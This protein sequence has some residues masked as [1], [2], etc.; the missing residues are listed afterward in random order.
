ML[1]P[2]GVNVDKFEQMAQMM[3]TPFPRWGIA[4]FAISLGI[5]CFG[6]ATELALS[7]SYMFGEG[8]GWN[9]SEDPSPS[10]EA[11]FS[12]VYTVILILATI[13]LLFGVDPLQ[14][15]NLSMALTA[16]TLPLAVIPFLILMND[17]HYLRDKTNGIISN[18]VV[19]VITL[20]ACVVAI[21]SIPLQIF[22]GG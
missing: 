14:V 15:T 7:I 11:R 6:A 10:K 8:L 22:G 3:T 19:V 9:C 21:V 13:P 17:S 4:L 1:H 16:A 2:R 20:L 18:S 5:T 12:T